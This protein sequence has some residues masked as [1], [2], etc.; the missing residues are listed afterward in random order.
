MEEWLTITS[1]NKKKLMIKVLEAA[2]LHLRNMKTERERSSCN[3]VIL[4]PLFGKAQGGVVVDRDCTLGLA[5]S[6]TR[7]PEILNY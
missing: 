6:D 5:V 4:A 3:D 2:W 7:P 1:H